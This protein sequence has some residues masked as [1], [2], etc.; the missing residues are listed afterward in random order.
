MWFTADAFHFAWKKVSDNISLTADIAF[1]DKSG[2]EHKKA[3]LMFRQ[4]LDPDSRMS[5]WLCM[6]A[7]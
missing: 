3:V 4:S 6:P 2:N 1:T 5:T 7:G